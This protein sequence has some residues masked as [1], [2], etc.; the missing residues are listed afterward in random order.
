M[1]MA[2]ASD[3]CLRESKAAEACGLT[4]RAWRRL[5]KDNEDARQ[6]WDEALAI[7]RDHLLD[8][9]YQKA[10][11][12]D[13]NAARLLLACRHG[14][15]ERAPQGSAERVSVTFNLPAPMSPE[16]YARLVSIEK[17]G[18]LPHDGD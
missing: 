13:T 17:Q 8:A 1:L 4:L 12:G 14:L 11:D 7:E 9:L 2:M 5:L 16:D 6:T 15:S 10:T 3:G 18:A